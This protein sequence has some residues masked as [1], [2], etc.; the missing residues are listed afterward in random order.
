MNADAWGEWID[1][2]LFLAWEGAGRPMSDEWHE[3]D[4]F[5]GEW[6]RALLDGRKSD[7][8]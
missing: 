7:V 8:G 2:L 5:R 3:W 1:A 6:C 4:A